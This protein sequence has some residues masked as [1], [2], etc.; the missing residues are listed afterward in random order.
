[1][2]H[3]SNNSHSIG[4][5]EALTTQSGRLQRAWH[6]A[7]GF[8]LRQPN[9][10]FVETI[11]VVWL[12]L[13]VASVVL[14]SATWIQFSGKLN[15][16]TQTVAIRI[17]LEAIYNLLLQADSS[18][19]AYVITGDK[20][21]LKSLDSSSK[22][23]PPLFE[24]LAVLAQ[25]DPVLL[26]RV[27]DLHGQAEVS[28]N[29]QH[30]VVAARQE[31]GQAA[32]AALVATGEGQSMM[33]AIRKDTDEIANERAD[34]LVSDQDGSARYQ[35]KRA[36]LT[37]L[38][39]GI[40]GIG[41]GVLAFALSR[42]TVKHQERERELIEARLQAERRSQEKTAFL[43]NMSHEIRT[44]MNAILGF[45]ELLEEDL[46]ASKHRTYLQSI[47]RSA[48][49]LLQLINDMLD[50]SKIEAGVLELR[51]EPTDPREICNFIQSVFSETA[52]KKG[53]WMSC[54]IAGD[55]PHAL[56][57]DRIR[58][59]QILVNLVGNAV[60]FTDH[61]GIETRMSW[62]KQ[63]DGGRVTLVIE[64]EDTGVGIPLDRLEAIFKPFVQ[65]GAH[66]EKEN[67][68]AGLGLSIVKRLTEIMA[69]T[70]TASSMPGRG[71]IFH[72]R[73]PDVP[74]S[75]RLPLTEL[76]KDRVATDFNALRPS[77]LLAVDDNETNRQLLG[78]MFA[79]SHHRLFLAS[80]GREAVEKARQLRPDIILLDIRMP[81]IDGCEV[82]DTLRKIQGLE[83]TPVI[84]ITASGLISEENA[85]K[86]HFSGYVRKPFTRQDIFDQL[87]QFLPSQVTKESAPAPAIA[88]TRNASASA[89]PREVLV[90]VQRL[91]DAEWPSV[92]DSVAINESKAFASKLDV[93]GRR[94]SC[95]PLISYARILRSHAESY[96]VVDLENTLMDFSNVS[97]ELHR[98]ASDYA[99]K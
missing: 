8:A 47:R 35:L 12:T 88:D 21:F 32:A 42:L 93:L 52:A 31:Q 50:M 67:Q 49:S 95:E 97:R 91:M 82:L 9:G 75:A 99:I 66:R 4:R 46:R 70:V 59:R 71:S 24:Q 87:A 43:A 29:Y 39:A 13:S 78:A 96:A 20:Q 18:Q 30:R 85:M 83:V 74:V 92:R 40:L 79:G 62:E 23:L 60:K 51:P 98:Q 15:T 16:A 34:H 26:K 90:E 81:D 14:A 65:A 33:E 48:S 3:D 80:G 45:S 17:K 44:P 19:G 27:M 7:R 5:G 86:A 54:K 77:R 25:N 6:A 64:V 38:T 2:P 89:V 37:G 58:L 56:L 11:V 55:L 63:T 28:L 61:G 22:S 41:A 94:W 72:L 68:G 1:M 84:A 57:L 53:L 76:A 10:Q 73:F 36:S 69:G